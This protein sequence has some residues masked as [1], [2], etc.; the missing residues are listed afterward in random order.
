MAKDIIYIHQTDLA[1]IYHTIKSSFELRLSK[2][3]VIWNIKKS[4]NTYIYICVY[5]PKMELFAYF[6]F[7]II[8]T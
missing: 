4:I 2:I 3:S 6:Y 8:I 1:K 5:F 7:L